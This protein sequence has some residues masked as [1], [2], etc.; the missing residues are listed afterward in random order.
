MSRY[1]SFMPHLIRSIEGPSCALFIIP[2]LYH[3]Y[4]MHSAHPF[5]VILLIFYNG[6]Y[7]FPETVYD[8]PLMKQ[9]LLLAFVGAHS[10]ATAK[11]SF[12]LIV[13]DQSK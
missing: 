10:L 8:V 1:S 4:S 6:F 7:Q 2:T 13:A 11:K 5:H 12:L 3:T 9:I